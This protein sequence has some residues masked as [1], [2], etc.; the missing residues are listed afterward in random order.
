MSGP[1]YL[2]VGGARCGT[3]ALVEGLKAHPQIF[4]TDPKE[5]HYFAFH[6]TGAH[7]TA[8]GDEHTIN[9]VSVTDRDAYLALYPQ[10][11]SYAALG[12]A[13]V[14]TLY[15][16]REA[17]PE[18][19][20]MNPAMRLVVLLREPVARAFSAHQYMRARGLEPVEDFLEAVALEE[21]RI[22]AG[23]HHI[24]HYTAMSRYADAL[25]E[26]RRLVP[27]EQVGVW[28]YDDLDADYDRVLAEVHAFLGADPVEGEREEVPRVNIS[29]SPRSKV[30][31]AGIAAATASP[32]LRQTVKQLTSYRFRERVR[33][34]VLRRD[35]LPPSAV[36][37]LA[38][39][40]VED[41]RRVREL[42]PGQVP[43]WL[44]AAGRG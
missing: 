4:V 17:L 11:H 2:V 28:F 25:G 6:A 34:A 9:A 16:H 29:G 22:A 23:W 35:G 36:E 18:V 31:H 8:P 10:Q 24:W 42:V 13:S 44:E 5:P 19:L 43:A 20:A 37:A 30:V 33:R 21:E 38:P 12:D 1:T 32:R 41:L 7:F 27:A 15:R 26:L 40:F 3:S 14:S 39:R